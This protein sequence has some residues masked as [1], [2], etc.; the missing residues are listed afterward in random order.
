MTIDELAHRTRMTV[1]NIRAYQSRGLIPAPEMRGRTGYYGPEH[2]ERLRAVQR[3]QREGFNLEAIRRLLDTAAGD[4]LPH[5]LDFARAVA[6][7]FSDERPVAVDAQVFV[8]RWGEQL[9]PAIV[10]RIRELGFVRALDDGRW[11]IRSPRLQRAA[12]ELADLG[13]PLEVAVDITAALKHHAEAMA[14]A[15]VELFVANVWRPFEQAGEPEERWDDVRAALDRLRPLAAESLGAVFGLVMTEK[16][17]EA[18]AR[19]L[20]GL[21][22]RER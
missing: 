4:P 3:L 2:V 20:T 10:E 14:S 13:V 16:V 21:A 8:D 7:P 11:E 15:F 5:A 19:E 17:E 9:T 12:G 1:R 22:E 18:L 6:A